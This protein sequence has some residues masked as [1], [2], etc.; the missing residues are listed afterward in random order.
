MTVGNNT[1]FTEVELTELRA[2]GVNTDSIHQ[3]GEGK[4]RVVY[5]ATRNVKVKSGIRLMGMDLPY[6]I[7]LPKVKTLSDSPNARLNSSHGDLDLVDY[8][9]AKEMGHEIETMTP[10]GRRINLKRA[11][12]ETCDLE[13]LVRANGPVRDL[14]VADNLIAS[15]IVDTRKLTNAGYLH[16]DI[17]PDNVL[18]G[19]GSSAELSDFE[20]S[21][22]A[23]NLQNSSLPTRGTGTYAHR[24]LLNAWATG[25]EAK[26]TEKTDV[27]SFGATL[28]YMF[29]GKRPSSYKVIQDSNG[30][31]IEVCGET[32]RIALVE[33][34]KKGYR[35]LEKIEDSSE[36]RRIKAMAREVPRA[37]GELVYGCL[38][39]GENSFKTFAEVQDCFAKIREKL[40]KRA[41]LKNS[42]NENYLPKAAG[43]AILLGLSA[44][45]YSS[46]NKPEP[47]LTPEHKVIYEYVSHLN[48]AICSAEKAYLVSEF[49][50]QHSPISGEEAE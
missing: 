48:P 33:E 45:A 42:I 25:T 38:S 29:T 27:Y 36:E 16:R 43:I 40:T 49:V 11:Y 41:R 24:S 39:D 13:K 30:R 4:N 26:A 1:D 28:Y 9:V 8:E 19:R 2:K 23:A 5:R 22:K 44:I 15:L 6:V 32:A 3:I 37:Y 20:L 17:K 12:L 21:A 31:E 14:Y 7:T 10:E 46:S 18:V 35:K 50:R 34:T 47:V